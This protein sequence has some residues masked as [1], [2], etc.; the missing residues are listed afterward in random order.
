MSK[1]TRAELNKYSR[2]WRKNDHIEKKFNKGLKQYL[3]LKHRDIFNEYAWFY[4]T[5]DEIHPDVKVITKTKTFKLWKKAQLNC[6]DIGSEAESQSQPEN[7]QQPEAESQSQPENQQQPE[8]ESQS[9]P[10]N[11][12]QLEAESQSQP[13][14]Q[15]QPEAE[16]QSEP[17]NQQQQLEAEPGQRDIITEALREPL[18]PNGINNLNID[19]LDNLVQQMINDLQQD[20]D[21]RAMLNDEE[22][23]PPQ[24]WEEDEGIDMD[25]EIELDGIV[26]PFDYE[27]EVDGF[28]Y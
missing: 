22:L 6:E 5:I 4:N 23:F 8:A 20:D 28:D 15:Q 12:Q 19:Q 1:K 3:E 21:I 14:N 11:Q 9:E 25:I 24:H 7:Q 13:E 26:E 10:E 2:Q 16:S 27:L 18:S 17:E